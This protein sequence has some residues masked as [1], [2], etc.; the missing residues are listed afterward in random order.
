VGERLRYGVPL[1]GP[2]P[3]TQPI[4]QKGR[5]ALYALP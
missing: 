5:A 1:P 4:C 2:P 3:Q